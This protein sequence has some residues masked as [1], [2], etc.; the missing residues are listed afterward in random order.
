MKKFLAILVVL[1]ATALFAAATAPKA[2]RDGSGSISGT[3]TDAVTGNP[4]EGAKVTAGCCG[5]SAL[6]GADG[7][8][9]IGNLPAGSYRVKAMKCGE[10]E[11][12]EYPNLVEV[13]EGQHVE[14]I[15]ISLTP[16]GGSG[17]GS[18]SGTVYDK[19]TGEPIAGAKVM[20]GSCGRSVLTG[21][22]GA[23][24]ISGLADGTY[25]V[26]AMK[27]GYGCA[28]YPEPVVIE[29]GAAVTGIDI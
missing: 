21:D 22:D 24:T 4:I 18:I 5:R 15:D 27:C 14:G 19:Q 2:E 26:K 17:S 11:P 10:Y 8:Y 29:D 1:S 6:T 7:S 12:G 9:T 13:A 25:T 3:I 16:I 23:Y 20:A 28:T